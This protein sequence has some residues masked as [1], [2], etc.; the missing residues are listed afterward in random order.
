MTWRLEDTAEGQDLVW[1]GVESGVAPSPL[2]GTAN[3][4]NANISTEMGEVLASFGRT[5]QQPAAITGGN[6]TPDG[7]TLFDAPANLKGGQWIKVTASTVSGITAATNPTTLAIDYLLVGGG[8]AGGAAKSSNSGS[9]GGG[10]GGEVHTA[11]TNFTVQKYKITIGAG[12]AQFEG[13]GVSG[14][15]GTTTIIDA[16][17]AT[18]AD[19]EGGGGGGTGYLNVS[20]ASNYNGVAR[21]DAGGGG[22]G[23]ENGDAGTGG[24]STNGGNGG[25]AFDGGASVNSTGGGGGS[26]ANAGA[27]GVSTLGGNGAAGTSSSITGVAT[28]YGGGGGGGGDGVADGGAGGGG[29]AA[30]GNGMGIAGTDGLGGG[31]GGSFSKDNAH[32]FGAAGG[33]GIAVVAYATGSAL[34]IGGSVSYTAT[35][36]VHTFTEDDEFE[37][38]SIGTGGMYYVSYESS[39]DKI[40]LSTA[41][42]P[43]GAS[44]VTHGTTGSV[45]FDVL[46]VPDKPIA[47]ATEK[48]K[49]TTSEK[50]RYYILD[51]N[52]RVWVYDT[53]VYEDT[54]A[55]NGVGVTWM[56][57]DPLDYTASKPK[58]IEILNGWVVLVASRRILVKPTVN[59]GVTAVF[60]HKGW[61]TSPYANHPNFALSGSQGKMLYTDGNFIGEIFP[62]TSLVT[63]VA[64]IQ[65]YASYTASSTVG[66]IA[67]LIGGS[68]PVTTNETRVPVV[69]FTAQGG[70][71]PTAIL[72]NKVYYLKYNLVLGTFT[73]HTTKT[74]TAGL[75]IATGAS[76]TQYFNTFFPVG[77]DAGAGGTNPLLQF[78]S[79]RLN[80][81]FYETATSLL[82]IGNTVLIGCKGNLVYPW[83]QI[84]ATPSDVIQLPEAGV[85]TMVNVNNMAYL[86]A[87]NRGNVYISNGSVASLVLKVPDYCAGV[88]GTPNSYIEPYFTWGDSMY[89]RGRVYFSILDQ[90]ATKAGNTG[91]VW[92]FIPTGNMTTN[93]P[94]LALRLENQNSYGDYDGY[95]TILIP[96]AEQDAIAPQYW[97]AW[98]DSYNTATAAFGIDF[99][100]TTPVT[101]F[102][103]ETDLLVTGSLLAKTTF[104]QL[105]YK[106]TAPAV[107]GDSVQLFYRLN[108][109]AAWT[110]CGTAEVETE[111]PISGY[112]AVNF[113]KTQWIQ[114]RAVCSTGGTT[115]SSFTR[116]AQLRL[117]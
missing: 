11:T 33:D 80:L 60:M 104:G 28:V 106:L 113:E 97:A 6:L 102:V 48:Y 88:P 4:Q 72:P 116:L 26:T 16:S 42:D 115:A 84:D 67:I 82:E 21:T 109:N 27:N 62:T 95:A 94:G 38:L 29:R 5:A 89:C 41:Y 35:H 107:A 96:A 23:A 64:N 59:L 108:S 114:F 76:G 37:V 69:F 73:V 24:V 52:G 61:L 45:T 12:A 99:T 93:D 9:G 44:V 77:N 103:V 49:T 55:A 8:G 68:I 79:Q 81:P 3:I 110:S 66:T 83:N 14:S 2:K 46:A 98:Q 32:Y 47:K 111:E 43:Y 85:Q 25:N 18:V 40:K 39:T 70:V 101:T 30:A 78:T 90:T 54:L 7:T 92:S 20:P 74:I 31:G 13:L 53:K 105:E 65:S 100:A 10:G 19:A 71:L 17:A 15:G 117:R 58:G 91:G 1:D 63:S 86:F 56:L 22:A 87:G 112:Y 51:D 36:T 34:C 50:Y 75:D 57:P